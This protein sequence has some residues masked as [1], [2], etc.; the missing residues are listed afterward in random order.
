MSII[1]SPTRQRHPGH[2]P[3][4]TERPR[5]V[6]PARLG[7]KP[8][9]SADVLRDLRTAANRETA[10]KADRALTAAYDPHGIPA[11]FQVQSI[12]IY[13]VRTVEELA[14]I[15]AA[16][17][18]AFAANLAAVKTL[19]DAHPC[20]GSDH[21]VRMLLFPIAAMLGDTHTAY[22]HRPIGVSVGRELGEVAL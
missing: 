21:I 9:T 2:A 11:G 1:P 20:P 18:A 7:C 13:T 17:A 3:T 19:L 22:D 15:E 5:G 10:R 16:D 12:D 14:E 4:A 8:G 6:Q